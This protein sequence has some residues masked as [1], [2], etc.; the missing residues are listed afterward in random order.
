MR[1]SSNIDGKQCNHY[2]G[3]TWSNEWYVM[4]RDLFDRIKKG[5]GEIKHLLS[6]GGG[7]HVLFA[8]AH[9]GSVERLTHV[10]ISA[11]SIAGAIAKFAVILEGRFEDWYAFSFNSLPVNFINQCIDNRG[12]T[13]IMGQLMKRIDE[14][15]RRATR[16]NTMPPDPFYGLVNSE[17][18]PLRTNRKSFFL[19]RHQF[20]NIKKRLGKIKRYDLITHD[21]WTLKVEPQPDMALLSNAYHNDH[22]K[23][24]KDD[25]LVRKEGYII[26]TESDGGRWFAHN[27]TWKMVAKCQN[28][29]SWEGKLYRRTV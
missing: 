22:Q 15:R 12:F 1:K 17:G 9:L 20:D 21:I 25:F 27:P 28:G 29:G 24:P 6:V 2:T 16:Y 19:H 3:Y 11:Y 13:E 14:G 4:Y 26:Y 18:E 5:R 7:D 10:D 23:P 8:L